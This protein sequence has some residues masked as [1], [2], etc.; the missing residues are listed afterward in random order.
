MAGYYVDPFI[1]D[2]FENVTPAS[3]H[4]LMGTIDWTFR[5]VF[6][7]MFIRFNPF[8]QMF[9]SPLKDFQRT[10]TNSPNHVGAW[11]LATEY[12]KAIGPAR[13]RLKS[14]SNPIITEMIENFLRLIRAESRT[15]R[16][17]RS[18]L[19]EIQLGAR[20]GEEPFSQ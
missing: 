2:M 4:A 14:Q 18:D 7:P 10:F 3:A 8:F 5:N 12:L 13:A 1:A 11:K 16:Y 6:Y 9:S 20:G 17:V 15:S 19:A